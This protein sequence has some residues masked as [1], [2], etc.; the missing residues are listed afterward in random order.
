MT[1]H[2]VAAGGHL[3][4]GAKTMELREPDCGDRKLL[5]TDP[6]YGDPDDIVYRLRP[7]LHEPGPI[8]TRYYLSTPGIS[9]VRGQRIKLVSDYDNEYA[10]ARVMAIM[11]VY[12][13]PDDSVTRE[14]V[15]EPLP[16]AWLRMLR[17]GRR[18]DPPYT[19][20]P[21]N[22]VSDDGSIRAV[23]ELPGPFRQFG[24]TARVDLRN[25]AF[26]P[27]KIEIPLGGRVTWR[28]DDAVAHNVLLANGPA[29]I[30]TPTL[31][32]GEAIS[33]RFLRPGRYQL[34]CYLHPVTM[35]QEVVVKG[36]NGEVPTGGGAGL[37]QQD[38]SGGATA[39]EQDPADG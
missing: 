14:K 19:K 22:V 20:V 24:E 17:S 25:N 7:I 18:F 8:S 21:L 34:F 27:A 28:F 36:K 11:H 9:V 3:H 2:I 37:T 15:C 31:K 30:G 26:S 38:A 33:R 1:G 12:I 29:V 13:S 4:G 39:P 6:L 23:E 32:S 10:R 35:H 5:D 16:P